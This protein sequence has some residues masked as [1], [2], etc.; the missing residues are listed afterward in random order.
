MEKKKSKLTGKALLQFIVLCAG[1][2]SIYMP[3]FAKSTYYD[4]FIEGFQVSNV[5]FGTMFSVYTLLTLITYFPGGVVADKFSPRKLLTISFLGTGILAIWQSFFPGYG[6]A[7][8][9]YGAMGVTTTLTFW[10]AL[11]KATRQF[12]QTLGGESKALGSLEG[13]RGL[14]GGVLST[15]CVFVFSR[16]TQMSIGLRYVLWIYAAMLIICGVLAWFVFNDKESEDASV[17]K[18]SV[19]K[20]ILECLKNPAVWVVS[21]MVMGAYAMTS[22]M[23]GYISKIATSNFAMSAS[24]AA[25]VVLISTYVRPVGSFVGGWMGDKM[26]ATKIMILGV[27]GLIIPAAIIILL[28]KNAGMAIPFVIVYCIMTIFMGTVRGQFYAPLREARV[29]MYL[30]GTATGLIATIGYSPDLFLP[31]ISGKMLDSMDQVVAFKNII[32]IL[33]CFGVFSILMSLVMLKM[34]KK[35]GA[36][37]APQA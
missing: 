4:A 8:F 35:K 26:G 23:G 1:A 29:P 16:F 30:S 31:I 11:I 20:L 14:T 6:V 5:E 32:I 27:V 36:Q 34:M 15:L 10:A 37:D 7:L 33:I 19:G 22:T 12:G 24:V 9:I 17:A 3:V 28:P 13:G 18:E 25:L 2:T 21:L